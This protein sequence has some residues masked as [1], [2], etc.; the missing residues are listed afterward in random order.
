[1]FFAGFFQV[2]DLNVQFRTSARQEAF[3]RKVEASKISFFQKNQGDGD[4]GR[5]RTCDHSLRRRVLY[6]AERRSQFL[7]NASCSQMRLSGSISEACQTFMQIWIETKRPE[8]TRSGD[9]LHCPNASKTR[10]VSIRILRFQQ[11]IR[12]LTEQVRRAERSCSVGP[13]RRPVEF[14]IVRIGRPAHFAFLG[15]LNP[16]RNA[17]ALRICD[18]FF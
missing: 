1:M 10:L 2:P 18:S 8:A 15:F 6:P 16:V 11:T 14:E 17:M 5:I 4:S 3:P 12:T 9:R 7:R 13:G